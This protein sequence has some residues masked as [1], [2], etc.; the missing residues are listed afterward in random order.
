MSDDMLDDHQ[1]MAR[2]LS[3]VDDAAGYTDEVDVTNEE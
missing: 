3:K 1:K 2:M